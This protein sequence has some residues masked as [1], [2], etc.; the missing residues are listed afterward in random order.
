VKLLIDADILC[1]KFACIN[2]QNIDWGDD[3]TSAVVNERKAIADMSSYVEHLKKKSNCSEAILVLSGSNNFRYNVL[4]TYKH[5]RPPKPALVPVLKQYI[6]DNF[7]HELWDNL[8]GDDVI[9]I[10]MTQCPD[11]YVCCTKDKDLKQIPGTH[12]HMDREEFFYVAEED[13]QAFFY[14]QI[15]TGDATDGYYGCPGVGKVA[16]AKILESPYLLVP[17][18]YEFKRGKRQGEIEVRYKE[19]PT[20]NLWAAIVSQYE[21]KGLT[22]ADALQQARV[23]KILT[24]SDYDATKGEVI[25]WNP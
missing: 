19:E 23:A 8:E 22:E 25:L 15:L 2:E 12:F 18:E 16:A 20:D 14:T 13:G 1:F 5:H 10:M 9:G 11:Q 3:I 21:A 4:P 24:A 6:I 17:Y 7:R